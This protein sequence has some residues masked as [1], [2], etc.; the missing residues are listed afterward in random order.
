MGHVTQWECYS[1]L[2]TQHTYTPLSTSPEFVST[3]SDPY[4][5]P[6]SQGW[7]KQAYR[8]LSRS[9]PNL[10]DK[11]WAKLMVSNNIQ[12]TTDQVTPS[13]QSR[14]HEF[15]ASGWTSIKRHMTQSQRWVTDT[16]TQFYAP[17]LGLRGG[18]EGRKRQLALAPH[19]RGLSLATRFFS[20]IFTTTPGGEQCQA[21]F[22]EQ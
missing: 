4:K 21:C 16:Q 6:P 8:P 1:S 15:K 19:Q 7:R 12:P 3:M 5:S 2:L 22:T 10:A 9:F 18:N 13:C 20:W 17:N 14:S 11:P